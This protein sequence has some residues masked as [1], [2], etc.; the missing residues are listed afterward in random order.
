MR[1]AAILGPGVSSRDLDDFQSDALAT[2]ESPQPGYDCV[3]LFGG[4]GTVHRHL[5]ELLNVQTPLLVVPMGSGNDFARALGLGTRR[6]ALAA[7]RKFCAGGN[8]LW[9]ID[10][11]VIKGTPGNEHFFVCVAGVGLDS[12]VNRVANR[13]PRWLRGSGGYVLALVPAL[14]SFRAQRITL[15]MGGETISEPAMLAAFAN[16]PAYGH[17]M[18]IAPRAELSDGKLDICFVRRTGKLRLLALF[19]KVFSGSHLE[20]PEVEYRQAQSFRVSSETPLDIYADGE[21]ICPTPV[22]ISVLPQALAVVVP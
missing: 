1:A 18:R 10:V 17:R 12:A 7:W 3:L 22:E 19:P 4:D 13:L 5:P 15:D 11:G 9:R 14:S 21:Y 20:R 2:I 8:N 16:A 6:S